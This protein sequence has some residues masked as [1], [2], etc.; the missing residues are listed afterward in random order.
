ME[1]R[2]DAG[3]RHAGHAI[4]H[5]H[6]GV[7]GHRG[8]GHQRGYPEGEAEEQALANIKDAIREYLAVA[9]EVA[10]AEVREVEAAAKL[11]HPHIVAALD[12]REERGILR[13]A[14]DDFYAVLLTQGA[15]VF[16]D[17]L[18]PRPAYNIAYG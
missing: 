13:V 4:Q 12:A 9:G 16:A 14:D 7:R 11:S 15:Q 18:P 5:R 3:A 8:T 6:G 2:R 10:G 1:G 17:N